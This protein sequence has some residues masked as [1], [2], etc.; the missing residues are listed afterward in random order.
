MTLT[1]YQLSRLR[2]TEP[3]HRLRTARELVQLTQVEV[4]AAI[5]ITQSALSALENKRWGA[6][7]TDTAHKFAKFFGCA[8]EDLFPAKQEVA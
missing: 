4:A 3:D 2:K 8:I 1:P 6:T 7:S 5:G